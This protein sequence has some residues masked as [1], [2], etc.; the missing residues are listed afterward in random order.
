MIKNNILVIFFLVISSILFACSTKEIIRIGTPTDEKGVEG[1]T[2]YSEVTDQK[3]I[4]QLRTVVENL[5]RI[6][7]PDNEVE[8]ADIYFT[9]DKPEEYISEIT[10]YIWY[11]E[12]GTAILK[13]SDDNYYHATKEQAAILKD[14]LS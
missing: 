7:D 4:S 11:M 8:L 3:K 6:E 1:V 2:F 14:I 5:E 12:D 9:L 10:A 13:R